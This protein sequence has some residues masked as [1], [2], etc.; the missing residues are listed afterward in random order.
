MG[1]GNVPLAQN[2]ESLVLG[3]EEIIFLKPADKVR[4]VKNGVSTNQVFKDQLLFIKTMASI[5]FSVLSYLFFKISKP[6]FRFVTD[7]NSKLYPKK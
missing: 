7:P 4:R 6:I 2:R 3:L 5:F 1:Y